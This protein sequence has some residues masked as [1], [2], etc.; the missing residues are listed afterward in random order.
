MSFPRDAVA[1]NSELPLG[2]LVTLMR[3][4]AENPTLEA[5]AVQLPREHLD[6]IRPVETSS[7]DFL[8]RRR[9]RI[10]ELCKEALPWMTIIHEM[11]TE[12]DQAKEEAANAR[13]ET[14]TAKK[15]INELNDLLK[16]YAPGLFDIADDLK[17]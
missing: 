17:S 3:I 2:S 11:R 5:V 15:L 12:R 8:G 4:A 1:P 9:L 6:C 16:Q 13:A 14:E 10:N 7:F